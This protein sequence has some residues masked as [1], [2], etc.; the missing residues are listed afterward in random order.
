MSLFSPW[1]SQEGVT[2]H[3]DLRRIIAVEAHRRR[4]GRCPA[5]VH[6]LG[7]GESFAVEASPDGFHDLAS[8]LRV[9]SEPAGIVLE[10]G[11]TVELRLDGDV[12][13]SG[14]DAVSGEYFTGRAGGGASVTL[15]PTVGTDYFQYAMAGSR[16]EF[17]ARAADAGA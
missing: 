13:F 7:T 5:T 15:Y 8:G 3:P 16:G 12:F 2:M 10:D 6:A 17:Y 14:R 11:S 9:R 1:T 4:T